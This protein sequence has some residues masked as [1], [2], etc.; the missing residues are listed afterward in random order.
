M[1]KLGELII[2]RYIIS[3]FFNNQRPGNMILNKNYRQIHLTNSKQ[4]PPGFTSLCLVSAAW[5]F[6]SLNQLILVPHSFKILRQHLKFKKYMVT[7]I[8]NV[9][10]YCYLFQFNLINTTRTK[11]RVIFDKLFIKTTMKIYFTKYHYCLCYS[12]HL[13]EH[14]VPGS[15]SNHLIFSLPLWKIR[16]T[17]IPKR[18]QR[19]LKLIEV[20]QLLEKQQN[21]M[22]LTCYI[23][24]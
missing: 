6:Q 8:S 18:Q 16:R 12:S 9:S 2:L 15:I 3:G 20:R 7:I 14:N 10:G 23:N 4:S 11:Y 24:S 5:S 13:T 1:Q 22:L 21:T 17:S 19:K